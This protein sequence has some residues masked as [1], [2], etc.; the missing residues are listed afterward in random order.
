MNKKW[1]TTTTYRSFFLINPSNSLNFVF[2]SFFKLDRVTKDYK[3]HDILVI[4]IY[5]FRVVFL[6]YN[7][8]WK[9]KKKIKLQDFHHFKFL[10]FS[11]LVIQNVFVC[12]F[13][14]KLSENNSR[15]FLS[16]FSNK[17]T[18]RKNI[19]FFV[20]LSQCLFKK[21]IIFYDHIYKVDIL[22]EKTNKQ[23]KIYKW[24]QTLSKH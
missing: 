22:C 7:Q 18:N 11:S 14:E 4:N 12:L 2:V 24:N 15:R 3:H 20:F 23:T 1:L 13:F 6:F 21:T 5:L 17:Q 16:S 8:W 19:Q 9:R 10:I